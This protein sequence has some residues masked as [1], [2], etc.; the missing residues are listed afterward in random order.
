M[1]DFL[2]SS[3]KQFE[4]YRLLG[5]K[6]FAQ[7]T[8]DQLFWEYSEGSNS[9]A[10]VVR[11]LWGNMLSRWTDFLTT[12]G[13]KEWRN[14]DDEFENNITSRQDLLDKWNE[15][16]NCLFKTL[17]SLTPTDLDRIVYIRNQGHTVME[18]INRQLAHYPY[19]V[20]QIVLIGKM[21]TG[22]Q[23]K[24]LSIPR[25]NSKDYNADKFS[26]PKKKGHFTDDYL[27]DNTRV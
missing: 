27:D 24:S 26:K 9:I 14:R 11:H 6:T 4:Y 17:N 8:D 16:W 23:W 13:E 2:D 22:N 25:C 3:I 7:L 10:V 15:G 18:A 1:V 5:D 21:L 12:D 19:H 20:G